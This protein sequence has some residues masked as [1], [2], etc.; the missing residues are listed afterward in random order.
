MLKKISKYLHLLSLKNKIFLSIILVIILI[1]AAIA[2]LARTILVESLTEELKKR[3]FAI[4][5]SIAER[6][7]GYVLD[8]N[9]PRLLALIFDEAKL[10]ERKDLI[11]YIFVTNAKKEVI[12]NTFVR[13]FPKELKELILKH[14]SETVNLLTIQGREV[15]DIKTPIKEGIYEIG[16]VHVGLNK[17]HIDSLIAKLRV[18]FLGFI[19]LVIVFIFWLSHRLALGITRPVATLTNA[20]KEISK[21]NFEIDVGLSARMKQNC[22]AFKDQSFPC[23]H[24]DELGLRGEG[25]RQK[26]RC[27]RCVFYEQERGDEVSQLAYAFGN[28]IWSIRLYRK[29]LRESEQK[30]RSLFVSGPDPIFVLRWSDLSILDLNPRASEVY[31]FDLKEAKGKSFLEF[32]PEARDY[33][34]ENSSLFT[35]GYFYLTKVIHYKKGKRPFFVNVHACPI[36]YEQQ[37]AVIL[38][39]MDITDM[40]EKD[41]QIIQ[42]SKM[43]ALGEMAA[44]MAHEL[45]Q[46]L[47]A[48][49]MGAD[50]LAYVH[51]EEVK[52]LSPKEVISVAKEISKQVDRASEI[53]NS[54]RQFSR[55][56]LLIPEEVNLNQV[57]RAV[58]SFL[59]QQIILSGIE[60]KLDL[61]EDIP[62]ILGYENRLQQVVFN[63]LSNAKDAILEKKKLEDIKGLITIKTRQEKDFLV[64]SVEDNGIGFKEEDKDKVFEPFFSTKG[65]GKGMGLGLAIVKSIVKDHRGEILLEGGEKGAIFKIY[66]PIL[67]VEK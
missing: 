21:G 47:N 28:M 5:H 25:I 65:K 62:L 66:L 16:S 10:K 8:Q 49:K 4:G 53:I 60:I 37:Q 64:L 18:T 30:Y 14:A 9:Y 3:G 42:A 44:G 38:S 26:R 7:S 41:A 57:V 31:E 48:I 11:D 58:L 67:E 32:W 13:P 40:I 46:P 55:K 15:F 43:K 36:S 54:L 61:K 27:Q 51:L 6:G 17:A 22:P 50:L 45:N 35:E 23:W 34:K 2:L 59:K 33:F 56:S 52:T 19:S 24:L 12:A 29:R 63:L 39:C 20:A 1:S